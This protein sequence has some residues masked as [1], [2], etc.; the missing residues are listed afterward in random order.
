MKSSDDDA[1]DDA[2]QNHFVEDPGMTGNKSEESQRRPRHVLVQG[3]NGNVSGGL[4][5]KK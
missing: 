2:Q 3:Y 1:A 4:W 5:V